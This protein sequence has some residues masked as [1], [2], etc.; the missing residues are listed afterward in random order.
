MRNRLKEAK[1]RNVKAVTDELTDNYKE[2]RVVWCWDSKVRIKDDPLYFECILFSDEAKVYLNEGG[3]SIWVFLGEDR[4]DASLQV[5]DVTD[6]KLGFM[7]CGVICATGDGFLVMVKGKL[8]AVG[9]RDLQAENLAPF[10]APYG[11]FNR[12][13]NAEILLMSSC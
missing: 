9:Y 11:N 7:V 12:D 6:K 3:S 1:A 5:K 4:Y 8:D 2:A 13:R 10:L